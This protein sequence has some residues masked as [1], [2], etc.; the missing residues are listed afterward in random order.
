[1]TKTLRPGVYDRLVDK[2]LADALAGTQA[3]HEIEQQTIEPAEAPRYLARHVERLLARAVGAIAGDDEATHARRVELANRVLQAL[4]DA[5][6]GER[7]DI[8]ADGETAIGAP[9]SRLLSVRKKDPITS[10]QGWERPQ[11]PLSQS[12]LLVNAP[13]EPSLGSEL[14][15]E[16]AS[17]DRV[18]LLCAFLK[19]SG[20]RFVRDRLAEVAA[21]GGCIRVV[22]TTYLGATDLRAIDELAT[23]GAE[24]RVS[25]DTKRTRLHAKAWLFHRE[26]GAHT[27]YI[28]SSNLSRAALHEGLEWNVRL[29]ESDARPLLE[30]FRAAFESY[31]A[32]S[33]FV[34]YEP[35]RDR[36]RVARA[37]AA[38]RSDGGPDLTL[39]LDLTPKPFQEEI[40]ESLSVERERGHTRNLVVAPTGTGKTLVA[41]FDYRRLR[42]VLG[43]ARLLFVA[44]RDRI[45]EQSRAAF[46]QVLRDGSFGELYAGGERP[47][48]GDHV[49]ATVQSL[50]RLD[51]SELAPDRFEVVIVDEFHHAE[52]PTYQ[53]LLEHLRPKYLLG[54]TATPERHDGQDIRRWFDDRIA[55]EMRLWDAL[56]QGLL[57]PF[58]YYGVADE[59]DLSDVTW[60]RAGYDRGEL[61]RIYTGNDARVRLVLAEVERRVLDARRMRALG[62]CVSVEHA[63]FMA[64]RFTE[65]GLRSEAVTSETPASDRESCV[66]KLQ[67]RELQAIFTVDL[68]NEGVDI[69]E[70]DTVLFLRPTE[71]ATVFLQ[72][73]GRGL[74]QS[75]GK[76]CLT[77]LDFIGNARKEFRFDRRFRALL[78]GSTR[79]IER[80]IETGFPYL[81]PGCAMQL[82][83]VATE[84]VLSNIKRGIGSGKRWLTEELRA[85]GPE[86]TFRQ[87]LAETGLGVAELYSNKRSFASLRA[88]AFGNPVLD[89]AARTRLARLGALAHVDDPERLDLWRAFAA[90]EVSR[91]PDGERARRL[92]F[93]LACVLGDTIR[94]TETDE[95]LSELARGPA[96]MA[97]LGELVEHLDDTRR[98][99]TFPWRGKDR[100][101]PVPL[102]LHAHYRQEEVLGA[103][104]VDRKGQIPRLQAGVF[105]EPKENVDLLFVTLRKTEETFSPSTM[106]HDYAI[107][108]TRFHWESQNTAHPETETGRRY[109]AGSSTV[110]LFLREHQKQEN[111]LAEPYLFAGP[112]RLVEQSGARPMQIVWELETPLPASTYHRATLAAG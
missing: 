37:L 88:D 74:R 83:R 8:F 49:F 60:R 81:P 54:L 93:M 16:L 3:D 44:H 23:L 63:R 46:R 7:R 95:V 72:Q 111:G 85:L 66:R 15:R 99:A 109:L 80:Q 105:Y 21:R 108:P 34:P 14:K 78:G 1:M 27:A 24:V 57:C 71:S 42:G 73:L 45:L 31:W 11:V 84:R 69:P 97:E 50:S 98:Q 10:T 91:E 94:W 48:V 38:E 89:D 51:L 104:G 55:F 25:F 112:V 53:R 68:F 75:D 32:S 79:Q 58:Q 92:R 103:L 43:Q 67:R 20:L 6:E 18:D 86:T 102:H 17:A 90:G 61:E 40:L 82:D 13:D 65:A 22:T 100:V 29:S 36:E 77:V 70:V 47:A 101:R 107:S 4:A 59:T 87:F 26:S 35:S 52:A 5:V 110:L 12:A 9:A 62:F 2:A 96:L 28:G 19:W 39:A 76:P 64:K 33:E 30:K 106:Y 41:A 56:E